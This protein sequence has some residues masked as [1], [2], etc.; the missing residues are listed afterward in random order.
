MWSG[1]PR[2]TYCKEQGWDWGAT[3]DMDH[4]QHTREVAFSGSSK[5]QPERK[6]SIAWTSPWATQESSIL[7]A[8]TL[9]TQEHPPPTSNHSRAVMCP[10]TPSH[11]S[12]PMFIVQL[13]ANQRP[14]GNGDGHYVCGCPSIG[15]GHVIILSP[16]QYL[17][18]EPHSKA[19]PGAREL[20]E[21]ARV[22]T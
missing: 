16:S 18:S 1:L 4:G 3:L 22:Y 21:S 6:K 13:Q 20:G 10:H 14:S 12:E 17:K 8:H 11:W 2:S 15:W 19:L 7:H 9:L 5:E